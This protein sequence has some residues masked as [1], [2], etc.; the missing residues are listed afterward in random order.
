MPPT[1]APNTEERT[2]EAAQCLYRPGLGCF[3]VDDG[4]LLSPLVLP[5]TLLPQGLL[6]C[7]TRALRALQR[8]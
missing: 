5:A 3:D 2:H 8:G 4:M 7:A 6:L 1:A